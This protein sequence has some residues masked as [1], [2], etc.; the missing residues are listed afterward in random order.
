[1]RLTAGAIR[2]APS[3]NM[4]VV[5]RPTAREAPAGRRSERAYSAAFVCGLK[6]TPSAFATPAP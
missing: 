6:S 1:M 3:N 5:G 4:L 2:L